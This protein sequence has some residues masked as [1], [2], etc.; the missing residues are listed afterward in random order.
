MN[1]QIIAKPSTKIPVYTKSTLFPIN[2]IEKA[3]ERKENVITLLNIN[4]ERFQLITNGFDDIRS[5]RLTYLNGILEVM[6]LG[7]KHEDIKRTLCYLLEAY[8]REKNIRFYGRGSFTLEKEGY[9]ST[10]PDE[11]YCIG[12]YKTMPDIV[13]EIIITSGTVDKREL[14]KPKNIP[15]IWFWKDNKIR[16]FHLQSEEY[17]EVSRSRFLPDLDLALLERYITHPDQYDAVQEFQQV[18]RAK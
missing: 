17:Q 10:E 13:I 15:E 4:W 9:S 5:I 7:P 18:I 11:S 6:V 8:M 2:Q 14:Y 3:T 1:T 16:I 12:S